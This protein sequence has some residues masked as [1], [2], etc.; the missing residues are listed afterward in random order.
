MPIK[1]IKFNQYLLA[2]PTIEYFLTPPPPRKQFF[3][4]DHTSEN[5][6]CSLGTIHLC[7]K[8]SIKT[9]VYLNCLFNTYFKDFMLYCKHYNYYLVYTFLYRQYPH[10]FSGIF[11]HFFFSLCNFLAAV[12]TTIVF[13]QMQLYSRYKDTK[14]TR[15]YVK[16]KYL[17]S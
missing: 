2:F 14:Y 11:S 3:S 5:Y 4:I 12:K 10:F 7:F 17:I 6:C 1:K 13:H 9:S 15:I 8:E 16:N